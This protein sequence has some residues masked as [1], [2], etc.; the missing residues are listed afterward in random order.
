MQDFGINL[1]CDGVLADFVTGICKAMDIPYGGL[2][3]WPWGRCFDFFPLA[4]TSYKEASEHCDA[5][6]WA[7]LPWMVDGK[8]IL[9]VMWDRFR[10]EDV[11]L[12]TKP[13]DND[14]S[15]TGKAK[16]VTDNVPELRHRIVPTHIPKEEFAHGF[17]DLLIDDNSDN[18]YRWSK[19]GGA[20]ILVPRPWNHLD[21]VFF[22][23]GAVNWIA[24][25]LDKWIGIVDYPALNMKGSACQG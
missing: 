18:V 2:K 25:A 19:A 9:Q 4:N 1:D 17:H 13:M 5:A 22:E 8:E 12:L 20:A 3:Q 7:N 21:Y 6:F 16:W 24:S 11:R 14:G 15:Y 23:G 10:P